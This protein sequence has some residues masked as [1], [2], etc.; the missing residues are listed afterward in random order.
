MDKAG[1]PFKL[2]ASKKRMRP[3]SDLSFCIIFQTP[4]NVESLRDT[5]EGKETTE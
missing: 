3:S 1:S 2:T 4:K 5:A